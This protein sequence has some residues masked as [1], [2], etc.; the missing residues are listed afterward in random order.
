MITVG[1][2]FF[3]FFRKGLIQKQYLIKCHPLS[4]FLTFLVAL[5]LLPNNH[6]TFLMKYTIF[7]I[8]IIHFVLYFLEVVDVN[9]QI[10]HIILFLSSSQTHLTRL[11][12]TY[13]GTIEDDGYGMLQVCFLKLTR[14]VKI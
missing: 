8:Q 3:F 2:L 11:H 9:I 7:N 12:I 5:P 14:T 1:F 10:L 13:E 6:I 4:C